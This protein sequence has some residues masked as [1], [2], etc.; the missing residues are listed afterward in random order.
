[1]ADKSSIE[2]TDAT[3]NPIRARRWIAADG[4]SGGAPGADR[5][6]L[7]G[8]HCEHAS[9]GCAHC[10]AEGFNARLGTQL[11]YKPGHRGDVEIYLDEKILL[12]P[13]RWK[14]PRKIFLGSMTDVFASFVTDEMLDRIFAVAALCPQH[15]LQVLT[16]RSDRMRAYLADP[17]TP[18]RIDCFMSALL[19]ELVDPLSRRSDDLRA[20]APA[21]ADLGDD[22]PLPNVWLGVS[23]EDQARADERIP[24]LLATP[25]AVRFLSCEPLLGR[26]DICEHLGIWW[27]CTTRAWVRERPSPLHWIIAGGESGA[28]ARPMHPDWARGLRDQCAAAGVPFFFKQWGEWAPD[29]GGGGLDGLDRIIGASARKWRDGGWVVQPRRIDERVITDRDVYRI[30]KKA[31]GRRLDGVL[32]DAMPEAAA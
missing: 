22:W 12:Q 17:E 29:D 15:V 6:A 24:D 11:P 31:A 7:L 21:I 4:G 16:K 18:N 30:G 27:N 14:R 8:W 32:H 19:E 28:K 25:A 5:R 20:T 2:W 26:V 9:P 13:L 10:Y 23:V 3:W 1:M